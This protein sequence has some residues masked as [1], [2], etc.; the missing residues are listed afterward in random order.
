MIWPKERSSDGKKIS[1]RYRSNWRG[2]KLVKDAKKSFFFLTELKKLV[3]PWNVCVEAEG[4][5]VEK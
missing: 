5:Y 1:I 4:D 3:K 2:T